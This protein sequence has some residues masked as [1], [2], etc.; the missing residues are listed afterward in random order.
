MTTTRTSTTLKTRR[1]TRMFPESG[2]LGYLMNK[3]V[4]LAS[5]ASLRE[6]RRRRRIEAPALDLNED[7]T[8]YY[9]ELP[10]S[11]QQEAQ[12]ADE[13]ALGPRQGR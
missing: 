10:K 2:L 8:D 5:H 12:Q 9:D 1:T 11:K 7:E 6:A 13:A 4:L 3:Y